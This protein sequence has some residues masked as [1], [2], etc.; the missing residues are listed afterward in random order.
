MHIPS[1]MIDGAVC[2]VTAALG[3]AGIT[4]AARLASKS[5][6]QPSPLR[7]ACVSAGIF[8]GQMLNYPVTAGTSGH[9]LGG[10]LAAALLGV[11]QAVLAVACVV[12][13][14]CLVFGD[15]GLPVLGANLLNMAV[16]GAGLG[17]WLWQ[18]LAAAMPRNPRLALG[19][20]AWMSIML[21]TLACTVELALA[22]AT[23]ITAA[24]PAMLG[25][26]ASIGFGEALL[27][28]ALVTLP[29]C[30]AT[31]TIKSRLAIP[32]LLLAAVVAA[33]FVCPWPDGLESAA[34]RVGFAQG[35]ASAAP[36]ADY[37][38]PA[39]RQA[40]LSTWLAAG[41]GVILV[42]LCAWPLA[43]IRQRRGNA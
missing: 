8:A 20:G 16:V 39:I 9:L 17:G 7:F 30:A 23:S 41:I 1:D 13:L 40:W 12:T 31:P 26:H 2:P 27:T 22:G 25:L 36:L 38:V 24:A 28:V 42:F 18:R 6:Q 5:N 10:V 34:L 3:V 21:A 35:S 43:R 32:A 15:G 19:L 11:P 4:V 29:A 37:M 33:P 14:Q